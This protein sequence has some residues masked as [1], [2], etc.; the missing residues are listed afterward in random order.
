VALL[1]CPLGLHTGC[2]TTKTKVSIMTHMEELENMVPDMVTSP[3]AGASDE[4]WKVTNA[5]GFLDNVKVV[6]QDKPEVYS[7]FLDAMKEYKSDV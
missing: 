3:D 5:I 6:F 2:H 4:T 7:K 1:E